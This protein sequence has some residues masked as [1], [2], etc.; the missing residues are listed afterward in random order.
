MPTTL[1]TKRREIQA[2]R[3]GADHKEA[4]VPPPATS[5]LRGTIHYLKKRGKAIGHCI[6]GKVKLVDSSTV[7]GDSDR[8]LLPESSTTQ[9]MRHNV[10][11]ERYAPIRLLEEGGNG[12]V[13]LYR[14]TKFGTLVAVKTIHH[15]EI[16]SLPDEVRILHLLGDHQ[17]IV[18]YHTMRAHPTMDFH[19]QLIF[20]YCLFG[21][22]VDYINALKEAIPELFIWHVF[23][24]V[25]AGLYFMH[26]NS[27][28][29]GDIKP[30]NILLTAPRDGEIYPLPRIADF[31]TAQV[32]PPYNV[33]YGHHCTL[34][35]QPPEAEYCHG[36]AA[37]VWAL[38]C[39]IHELAVGYLPQQ[40]IEPPE[41]EV[42]RWFDL[43]GRTVPQGTEDI[44]LYKQFC[45]YMAF[46][47]ANPVRIDFSS[48]C[49]SIFYSRLLYYLTMRALDTNHGS[50]ISTN[51]LQHMLPVL[52]S[53]AYKLIIVGQG[54]V[55]NHF[56]SER[57]K[58]M[59]KIS[60]RNDSQVF[61]EIYCAAA[62]QAECKETT[63][64][65]SWAGHLL[66]L[67]DPVDRVASRRYVT[68]LG[69]CDSA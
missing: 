1:A 12:T 39:I 34:G 49:T 67:M 15:D 37:D 65:L 59:S 5:F 64:I 17:N 29:H 21:D 28:V 58:E 20:E 35:W 31:D 36:P 51:D 30:P 40:D 46:H 42:G 44:S 43:S 2:S 50:R 9:D 69:L 32:N 13:H 23:K 4:L 54:S 11:R 22:L 41:M 16:L 52:E 55:L 62:S 53:L 14:D 27:V 19:V 3:N 25:A 10:S 63:Q 68:D 33:P 66:K 47:P 18:Q 8:R 60:F 38:G 61:R 56:D 45:F 6:L 48:S 57:D 24:H 26:Q 7:A